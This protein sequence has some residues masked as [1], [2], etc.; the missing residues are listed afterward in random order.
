LKSDR[1]VV[2][3]G[4]DDSGQLGEGAPLQ[5]LVPQ[6]TQISCP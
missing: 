1:S 3:W 6:P 5:S 2:C 4:A